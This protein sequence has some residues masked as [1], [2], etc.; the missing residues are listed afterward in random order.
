MRAYEDLAPYYDE[1]MNFM[2]Y[3]EEAKSLHYLIGE[4]MAEKILDIGAGS[5][6]HLLPL[7]RNGHRVDALDISQPMLKVLEGKLRYQ[8]LQARLYQGDMEDFAKDE[9]Y[10]LIYALGDTV[11]HL[12]SF[13]ALTAFLRRSMANLVPGG[14]LVFT[15]RSREYFDTLA[16]LE[17]FYETHG[18]DYL[19]WQISQGDS[20]VEILYTAFLQE[21]E[22]KFTRMREEH[23]LQIY[24]EAAVLKAAED[25]GFIRRQDLAEAYLAN[26]YD[27]EE[28]KLIEVLEKPLP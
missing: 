12:G 14:H 27:E 26:E 22:E 11:H 9:A 17:T 18:E 13:Q 5:G 15:Y 16:A 10:D 19:L 23:I 7:L 3:D 6:G 4:L 24:E 1:F 8:G 21:G 2:E 28:F 25:A 20:E